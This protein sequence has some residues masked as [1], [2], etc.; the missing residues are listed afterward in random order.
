MSYRFA[1]CVG[2]MLGLIPFFVTCVF[3]GSL[4]ALGIEKTPA[5]GFFM[6]LV[7]ALSPLHWFFPRLG[8]PFQS[9]V[10]WLYLMASWIPYT[11]FNIL[12]WAAVSI[13]VAKGLKLRTLRK[14]TAE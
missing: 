4:P 8:P 9:T 13:L 3:I 14:K 7:R 1:A 12:W 2:A 5:P 6:W 11:V 10:D